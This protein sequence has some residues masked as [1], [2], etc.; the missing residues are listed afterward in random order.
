MSR[1][2]WLLA[3]LAVVGLVAWLGPGKFSGSATEDAANAQSSSPG[4]VALDAELTETG[5]DGQPLY[6]L[7]AARIERT[8]NGGEITL[9][10]PRLSYQPDA[11]TQWLLRA[12]RGQLLPDS[13]QLE[14]SGAIEATG[15]NA[16][17]APLTLRT[18]Q[19]ALNMKEQRADTNG[20]V[21]LE[22]DQMQL[23]ALGLHL[24]LRELTWTLD[25]DGHFKLYR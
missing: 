22:Q 10:Q 24:N 12:D 9:S 14:L 25:G 20:R 18:A 4:Y 16:A 8:A 2:W 5:E 21:Y 6:R 23:N 11:A 1:L 7:Q 3:L 17:D 19:L 13:Q 15:G